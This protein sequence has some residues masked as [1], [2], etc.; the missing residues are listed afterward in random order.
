MIIKLEIWKKS[1]IGLS[2]RP[3]WKFSQNFVWKHI[4]CVDP[5]LARLIDESTFKK[6]REEEG[7]DE[8]QNTFLE[9]IL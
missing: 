1:I 6:Q 7:G 3:E 5:S 2:A 4:L 8:M 9:P